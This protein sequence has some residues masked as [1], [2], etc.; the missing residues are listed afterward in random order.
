MGE[1]FQLS[2]LVCVLI[3]Q[4]SISVSFY[5][6]GLAPVNYCE[7]ERESDRCKSQIPVFVNRLTSL[8][9]VIPYD[10]SHFDFCSP[11]SEA[12]PPPV[13]NLGQVVFGQRIQSSP[14]EFQFEPTGKTSQ[15]CVKV[16]EKTY[17]PKQANNKL[18]NLKRAIFLDYQHHFIVDNMPVTLCYM[19]DIGERS[20]N[21]GFPVGCYVDPQGRPKPSCYLGSNLAQKPGVHYLF[22]HLDFNITYHS[23]YKEA[24]GTSFQGDGGRIIRVEVTPRSIAH[25][26]GEPPHCEAGQ[27]PMEI[28]SDAAQINVIYTYSLTFHETHDVKWSSRW[29]YLLDSL[30]NANIQWFSIL[31]SLVIVLFLSGMVAMILLRTLHKDIARYNQ[32]ESGD[33]T[34]EEFGWKLVHGD[35]FRPPRHGMLLSVFVGS[36]VQVL[37]MLLITLVFACLGFLSPANRGSL[38]T[39]GLVLYVCLGTPAGYVAA[40]IYKSFG[41]EKW[42]LNVLLT[43]T[44]CPGIVFIITLLLNF[45]LWAHGSSAALPFL[46]ILALIGLWFG[47][48]V[49]LTFVGAYFGFRKRVLEHPVR[50]NQ[51]PRQIP[52]QSIYTRPLPCVLMG[53]ILPFGCIF[54]QLFFILSSIW[55]SQMYY[56]FGFLFLVFV[57]LVITCSETTVLLC[58]FHLCAEDYH[59][60]W[61]SFLTSGFTAFYLFCYCCHYFA[62]KLSISDPTSVFLYF[63]YTTIM[64][65]LF[66]IMTGTLGFLACFWFVRKIYSVVKVD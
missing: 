36:G 11:Q 63:G 7:K 56:M 1:Y 49:P 46:T 12:A 40:R 64:V 44:L 45:V 53:G 66:F 60:W 51:I 14:Y 27:A 10:Y 54:V 35:V 47:V 3:A 28:S 38:M 29:D 31:N 8:E 6:P 19:T 39:C 43:S 59:W 5:L 52:E 48:S 62:T 17:N 33:D 37:S 26:A 18:A 41:G 4:F 61:R 16:C 2:L 58:Y 34:Q 55:S 9:S 42:G 23:G 32:I 24:W 22:N 13:E 57:I 25:K 20:C 15:T 21:N 50:T 30:P 65:F